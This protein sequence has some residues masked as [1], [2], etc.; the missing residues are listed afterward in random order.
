MTSDAAKAEKISFGR[1]DGFHSALKKRVNEYFKTTGISK[2]ANWKMKLKTVILLSW[3]AASYAFLMF[4]ASTWWMVLAGAFSMVFV[5]AGIGFSIQHD[6]N[7]GAYSKSKKVN[8]L[9]GWTLDCLGIGSYIWRVKHNIAHHTY[10][11]IVGA[12]DDIDSAP[13]ARLS[14]AQPRKSYYRAQHGYMWFLYGFLSYQMILNDLINVKN[15]RVSRTYTTFARPRGWDL[16][17]F[18]LGKLIFATWAIALPLYFHPPLM[19][20]A[21][22]APILWGVG[23]MLA[24]V[25]QLAHCVEEAYFA[26]DAPPAELKL[27]GWAQHQVETTVDFAPK[28]KLISWYVGGLNFQIEHH[29][30]PKICH[31]HYPA[32]A[33]IVED[34]SAEFGVSY[35]SHPTFF[36]ALAS[37]YRWLKMLG[38]SPASGGR[39]IF[40]QEENANAA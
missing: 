29:L 12:D 21:V 17:G 4:G 1:D 23:V 2:N 22:A 6:A 15:K 34:T 25:F 24:V 18:I 19:V 33:K 26:P 38:R 14:P 9:L 40:V 39:P 5:Y 16:F 10:T 32:I 7:H 20:L 36:G 28:N 13:F 8:R 31:V 11:N 30:F 27:K 3:F 37:H 35:Y